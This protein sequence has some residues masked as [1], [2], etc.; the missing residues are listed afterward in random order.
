MPS[1]HP[2]LLPSS[3]FSP[4]GERRQGMVVMVSSLPEALSYCSWRGLLLVQYGRV[5]HELQC[6]SI[7]RLLQCGSLF[8]KVQSFKER[9]LQS[10][11]L[12]PYQFQCLDHLLSL[13]HCPW[14]LQSYSFHIFPH[15]S[16]LAKITFMQKFSSLNLLS[17]RLYYFF[18]LGQ[19]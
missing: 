1:P 11:L 6:E 12:S 2:F 14:Y 4:S 17:Q 7:P 19:P 8:H 3:S 9:L 15:Q 13:L 5:H 18:Q 16:P 10:C